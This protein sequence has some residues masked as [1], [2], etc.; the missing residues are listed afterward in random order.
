MDTTKPPSGAGIERKTDDLM[1][2]LREEEPSILHEEE[3]NQNSDAMF[4]RLVYELMGRGDWKFIEITRRTMLSKS[5][6]YQILD[7]TRQPSRDI[8]LRLAICLG[9]SVDETQQLLRLKRRGALYPRIHRDALMIHCLNRHKHLD[10]VNELLLAEG[11]EPLY[12][13]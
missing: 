2:L 6:L 8:V 11:E 13:P 9:A 3:C 12:V 7:G 4:R 1:M 5:F 10:E